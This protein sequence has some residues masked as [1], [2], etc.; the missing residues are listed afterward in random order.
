MLV[1]N[2]EMDHGARTDPLGRGRVGGHPSVGFGPGLRAY[3][4]AQELATGPERTSRSN[5]LFFNELIY[6]PA[7]FAFF[8][9]LPSKSREPLPAAARL[10][11]RY[12]G[13]SGAARVHLK[14]NAGGEGY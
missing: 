5:L 3:P 12:C 1:F 2:R 13:G 6:H 9:L 7:V 10:L 8:S 4:P 14:W 11:N